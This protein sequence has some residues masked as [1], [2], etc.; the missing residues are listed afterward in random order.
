MEN[1]NLYIHKNG[2]SI[3][4]EDIA[5]IASY[6]DYPI[7]KDYIRGLEYDVEDERGNIELK[8]GEYAYLKGKSLYKIIRKYFTDKE[9]DEMLDEIYG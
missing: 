9:I 6:Q 8:S 7:L 5:F 4:K 1:N 3:L 2:I